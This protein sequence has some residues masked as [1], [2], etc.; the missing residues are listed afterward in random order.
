[1]KTTIVALF[2][3]FAVSAFA[4]DIDGKWTAQVPGRGGNLQDTTFT[5]K[6]QGAALTGTQTNAQGQ[7]EISEGKISGNDISF[8]VKLSFN[9]NE[10]KLLYKGTVAGNEIKMNRQVEGRGNPQDFVAKR[11]AS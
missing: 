8:A 3:L 7:T 4:A 11:A 5:F 6:A 2:C 10:I 9:G 1:M